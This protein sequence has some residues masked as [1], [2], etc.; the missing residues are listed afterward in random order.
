MSRAVGDVEGQVCLQIRRDG[1]LA[2]PPID[3]EARQAI[4]IAAADAVQIV[5]EAHHLL[6][7]ERVELLEHRRVARARQ[8]LELVRQ[9]FEREQVVRQLVLRGRSAP[10]VVLDEAVG[11]PHLVFD[12]GDAEIEAVEDRALEIIAATQLA[13]IDAILEIGIAERI[14]GRLD[15]PGIQRVDARMHLDR[16]DGQVVGVID[17]LATHAEHGRADRGAGAIGIVG[18]RLC[19]RMM[20]VEFQAQSARPIPCQVSAQRL[21]GRLVFHQRTG[22]GQILAFIGTELFGIEFRTGHR[23]IGPGARHII[24]VEPDAYV[25]IAHLHGVARIGIVERR[26][27]VVS[28][29]NLQHDLAIQ[30]LALNIVEVVAGILLDLIDVIGAGTVFDIGKAGVAC[31][32]QRSPIIFGA[33][34]PVAPA[35]IGLVHTGLALLPRSADRDAKKAIGECV[36]N[37]AGYFGRNRITVISRAVIDTLYRDAAF[38]PRPIERAGRLDIDG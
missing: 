38:E 7:I 11:R 14:A 24:E 13:F 28:W 9:G 22:I 6:E 34:I 30:P 18:A 23:T 12:I 32:W 16:N 21:V 27:Q 31:L 26:G 25:G 33:Q 10:C 19:R 3:R 37:D 35:D 15:V 2:D 20:R 36:G 8:A 4:T 5:E 1:A 17:R 29:A